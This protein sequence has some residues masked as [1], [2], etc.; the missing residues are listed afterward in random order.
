MNRTILHLP[1]LLTLLL[2]AAFLA[3]GPMPQPQAYHQFAD[4]RPLFGVPNAGDVLSNAGFALVGL[5]GLI[6]LW[7]LRRNAQLA[8]G[9]PGWCLF[10]VALVLTA[11]GSGYY[12]LD[13]ENA[14]L[15]WDRVPIALACAGLLAGARAECGHSMHA[16][17]DTGLLAAAAVLT[18]LWWKITD[19]TGHGDLRFYLLLQLLTLTLIPLWQTIHHAPRA[20]RI[21]F[22]A[23]V[24]LYVVA[25]VA[26]MNDHA[27]FAALGWASGHTV[28]HLL[29]VLAAAL[30]VGHLIN[31][32]APRPLPAGVP[33]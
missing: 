33:V 9:W 22:G 18:V 12:H 28:K 25:K 19:R 23:A 7:P 4:T 30:L 17:R 27:L 29:S 15:F 32:V 21:A 8:A 1:L 3:Y 20:A 10:L 13:P 16:M 14:R 11:V 26:E 5:W 31:R 6:R 24:T 2:L